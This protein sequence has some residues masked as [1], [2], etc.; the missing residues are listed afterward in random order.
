[1]MLTVVWNPHGFNLIDVLPK[2]SKFNAGHYARHIP[3]SL[4]EMLASYQD[5]RSRHFVIHAGNARPHCAKTVTQFLDHN[6]IHRAPHPPYSPDL[7]F[8]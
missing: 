6:S 8:S 3:S 5:A 7:S 4:P 1:M 2:D